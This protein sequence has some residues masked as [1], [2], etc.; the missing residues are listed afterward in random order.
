MKV[1][2][3]VVWCLLH[4]PLDIYLGRA[5][6]HSGEGHP[7]DGESLDRGGDLVVSPAPHRDADHDVGANKPRYNRRN[8][9]KPYQRMFR[10]ANKKES[11]DR[12]RLQEVLDNFHVRSSLYNIMLGA[13]VNSNYINKKYYINYTRRAEEVNNFIF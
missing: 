1:S 3:I 7:G 11:M 4:I 5:D 6:P 13:T 8:P 12:R 10:I 9:E 2:W